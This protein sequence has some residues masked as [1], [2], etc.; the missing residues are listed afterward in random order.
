MVNSYNLDKYLEKLKVIEPVPYF[1]MLGLL[2]GASAVLTDSGGLQK[3]AYFFSK[4]CV[5]L[6]D[7]TEWTELVECG[8]NVIS[9]VLSGRISDTFAGIMSRKPDFSKKIYGTGRAAQVIADILESY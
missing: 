4:P 9:G 5:T 3:E 2:K 7:E 1:D 6:R 8:C